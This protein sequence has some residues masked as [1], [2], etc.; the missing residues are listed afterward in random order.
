MNET[1]DKIMV[2]SFKDRLSGNPQKGSPHHGLILKDVF[3]PISGHT[4]GLMFEM[5]RSSEGS[6]LDGSV[7]QLVEIIGGDMTPRFL[8]STLTLLAVS[9]WSRNVNLMIWEANAIAKQRDRDAAQPK[10]L[11]FQF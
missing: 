10:Q 8:I 11:E 1:F 9:R 5:Q 3:F 4:Y 2:S 6:V 7:F